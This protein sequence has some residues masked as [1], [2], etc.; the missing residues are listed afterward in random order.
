MDDSL[1]D[2]QKLRPRSMRLQEW[3]YASA[4]WYFITICTK[5]RYPYFGEIDEEGK[6]NF[7]GRGKIA[8]ECWLTIPSLHSSIELDEFVIMPDHLHGILIINHEYDEKLPRRWQKGSLGVIVN[9]FKG[10]V[11]KRIRASEYGDFAW[12][13]SFYDHVIRN[14]K[15][16]ERIHEYIFHN[17]ETKAFENE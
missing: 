17:P 3:N 9:Q 8:E 11:V 16:L 14:E 7:N 12:Q 4:G 15:D 10:A 5:D 1:A 2:A 13:R 6:M